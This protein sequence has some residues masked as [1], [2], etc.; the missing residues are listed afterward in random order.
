MIKK[1]NSLTDIVNLFKPVA[2]TGDQIEFYQNTSTVRDGAIYEYHDGLFARIESSNT[3]ER[4]LVVGHGGCG[5]ST[6]LNMLTK[7][8]SAKKYPVIHVEAKGDLDLFNFTYI[9]IFMLIV[10]KIVRYAKENDLN[11]DCSIILA[12][13]H[14]LYTKI[15][16]EYWDSETEAKVEGT[17]SASVSVPF[18]LT[19]IAKIT[20]ALKLTSGF[21]E[22]L[23][24]EIKPRI[25]DIISTLNTLVEHL[26]EQVPHPTV[27]IV[28][29]LEKCRHESV[30]R[31]F[32][33]DISSIAAIQ[34]HLVVSCPISMYRSADATILSGYFS[35]PVVIPMIKTHH[36]NLLP[37]EKG[38]NV[39]KELILK[40]ADEAFFED[41]VLETII[42]KA[43]GSLRDT[44]YLLSNSAFEAYM[45]GK[46]KIDMDSANS[47]LK[48]YATEIFFKVD[49][50]F[51]P[52]VKEI[53]DGNHIAKQDDAS[54]E[55]LY[56]GAIFEYNGNRWRD[57][58]PLVR[59][60][61][62]DN[63]EVLKD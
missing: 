55:L 62:Q 16:Q 22:E 14:A 4:L 43:G 34:A 18:F 51:Y 49:A 19:V 7:E 42:E 28:D 21:R 44:C 2:L 52:R 38:I 35:A 46:E 13:R 58:H 25:S 30:R 37:Y 41:D 50:K 45:R 56:T 31:L 17:V 61:I 33:E 39:I 5:K 53:Y 48:S 32:V 63:P 20:S 40:R 1:A 3:H 8:L 59:Q 10:E 15:T 29:G 6:E 27:I 12:F 26:N 9:D 47:V 57:L 24:G 11:V 23:R 36:E 60:Y 54:S